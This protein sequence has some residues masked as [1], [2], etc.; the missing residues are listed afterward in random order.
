MVQFN[1]EWLTY[2]NR[3]G[4]FKTLKDSDFSSLDNSG[5]YVIASYD[6]YSNHVIMKVG[7]S[8]KLKNRFPAYQNPNNEYFLKIK[9][10]VRKHTLSEPY[11]TWAEI[12]KE[13]LE[14]VENYLGTIRYKPLI[15][16]AFPDVRPIVVNAP[17]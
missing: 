11:I 7:K 6:I 5:V 3:D 4:S 13:Y 17:F 10:L 16:G 12:P 8:V 1:V 14:G 2:Y 9:N 15:S